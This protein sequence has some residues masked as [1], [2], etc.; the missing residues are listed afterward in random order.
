MK[1]IRNETGV[2]FKEDYGDHSS[3]ADLPQHQWKMINV[4][5]PSVHFPPFAGNLFEQRG[6]SI[7]RQLYHQHG[8][9]MVW[10]Y[11]QLLAKKTKQVR[12][13]VPNS[14]GQWVLVHTTGFADSN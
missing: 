1:L 4:T 2:D 6:L 10:E 11:D 3:P 7:A 8:S 5:L 9:A 13:S 14:P 12:R